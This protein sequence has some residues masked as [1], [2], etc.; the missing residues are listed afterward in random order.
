MQYTKRENMESKTDSDVLTKLCETKGLPD[1]EDINVFEP[2]DY[3]NDSK[4]TIIVKELYRVY[5]KDDFNIRSFIRE[6]QKEYKITVKYS[7]LLFCYRRLCVNNGTLKQ[8]K[9]DTL[10]S[11][12]NIG[13]TK[14]DSIEEE[15][16]YDKEIEDLLMSHTKR[17]IDG[18]QQVAIL[19]SP[20]PGID[21]V[22]KEDEYEK[23]IKDEL[24]G[25]LT[26]GK[27]SCEY[28][29]FFCPNQEGMPRSYLKNE[30]AVLRAF[31]LRFDCL[32]Q[33][34]DRLRSYIVNGQP[35]DKLEVLVLGGTWSS[36]K[37]DYQEQFIRDIYYSANTIYDKFPLRDKLSLI[38]ERNQNEYALC[39]IIGLTL[40]TRPDKINER[41]LLRF[42]KYGVTRVQMGVQHTDNDILY[43]INRRCRIEHYINSAKLLRQFG[44]KFDCHI[45]P[46]LPKPLK[47]GR[48]NKN[49]ELNDI[50]E[51]VDMVLRDLNMFW[52]M[53]YHSDYQA[54][55][56]KIYPHATVPFTQTKKDYEA[57]IYKSYTD[58]KFTKE[59]LNAIYNYESYP[60]V[61]KW[62]D[63]LIDVTQDKFII[64]FYRFLHTIINK[65]AS[66]HY[67]ILFLLIVYVCM[68]VKPYVRLNRIIRDIPDMYHIAGVKDTNMRQYVIDFMRKYE[69]NCNCIRSTSIKRQKLKNDIIDYDS[70]IYEASSGIEYFIRCTAENKKILLGFLRLRIDYKAGYNLRN[71]IIIPELV[72]VSMIRELHVYGK[73]IGTTQKQS[74][75][76][77]H[78]GIGKTLMNMAFDITKKN[79]LNKISVISG[80]GVKGYYKKLGFVQGEYYLIKDL[81]KNNKIIFDVKLILMHIL[82]LLIILVIYN[83]IY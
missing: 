72:N 20:Y 10:I 7:Y 39:H 74:K 53:I 50:D 61:D 29:C 56:W 40:E 13:E 15:I 36:Y 60:I 77:Q 59:A 49:I 43:R 1:L 3:S 41:E 14:E 82:F 25:D 19:T 78:R 80:E 12:D 64:N 26:A 68:H 75:H 63:L 47:D 83:I 46:D 55:Q 34:R 52:K 81:T 69:I 5:K 38:E 65:H 8:T 66:E 33:M 42:R 17:A 48:T 44:F 30:P 21:L 32:R 22:K 57:G 2:F 67:N 54:D 16:K 28:D 24:N 62:E 18:I 79:R 76:I 51:S 31:K 37:Q 6:K 9:Y 11:A 4:I 70:I 71:E 27:F 58:I 35:A 73:T 23:L 45:M